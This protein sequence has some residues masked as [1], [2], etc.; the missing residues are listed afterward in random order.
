M[1]AIAKENDIFTKN[2]DIKSIVEGKSKH[3]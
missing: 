2:Y 3:A 1:I